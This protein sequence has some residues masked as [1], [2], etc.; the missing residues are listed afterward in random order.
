MAALY[1]PNAILHIRDG[2]SVRGRNAIRDFYAELVAK[3]RKFDLGDQRPAIV[4]E[5]L[6][7]TSTRLPN[8]AVTAEVARRQGDGA[9]LWVIDNPSIA[10]AP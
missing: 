6:A 9:W 5:D 10:P 4:N 2:Q 8:G 1:E 3:G 7:L